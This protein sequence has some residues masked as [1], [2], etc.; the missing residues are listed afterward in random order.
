M[1]DDN[2]KR[3]KTPKDYEILS[4]V[5]RPS[6]PTSESSRAEGAERPAE[7]EVRFVKHKG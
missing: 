4:G 1:S 7:A 2:D 5:G 3:D 6:Y